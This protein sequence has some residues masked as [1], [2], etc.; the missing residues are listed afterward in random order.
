MPA[1]LLVAS[2]RAALRAGAEFCTDLGLLMTRLNRQIYRAYF[3]YHFLRG[4]ND[5]YR[6]YS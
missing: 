3:Y 1:S 2:V 5:A 6:I 4:V